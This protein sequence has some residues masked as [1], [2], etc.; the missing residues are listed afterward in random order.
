MDKDLQAKQEA[1]DLA[2]QAELAQEA[3]FGFPQHYPPPPFQLLVPPSE[4]P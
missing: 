2:K 1:R 3:L 4:L